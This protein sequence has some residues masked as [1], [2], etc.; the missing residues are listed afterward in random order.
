MSVKERIIQFINYKNITASQF[1]KSI[2]VSVA[3][4]SSMR[5]SIQPDKVQ[6]IANTYPELNISWLFTGGGNMLNSEPPPAVEGDKDRQIIYLKELL[7]SKDKI[8]TM[9]EEKVEEYRTKN[10][11][12]SIGEKRKSGT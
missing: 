1:C 7:K 9:L 8:I 3:F 10:N 11:V 6:S 5:K 4:V 12:D 2:G